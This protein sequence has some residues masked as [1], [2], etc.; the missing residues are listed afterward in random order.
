MDF[1]PELPEAVSFQLE[2]EV[3]RVA[4]KGQFRIIGFDTLDDSEW[5][6]DDL[7][8]FKLAKQHADEQVKGRKGIKMHVYNDAGTH[9]YEAHKS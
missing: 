2:E 9:L 6:E 1:D 3:S 4:P 7:N 5:L 8:T